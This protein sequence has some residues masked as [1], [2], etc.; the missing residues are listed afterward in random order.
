MRKIILFLTLLVL[1]FSSQNVLENLSLLKK[2]I[3]QLESHLPIH[4]LK[5]L[6]DT[7][8]EKIA[9]PLIENI[10]ITNL[11]N[12]LKGLVFI[13][14]RST[15]K[16][17]KP[18]LDFLKK[19]IRE[20]IASFTPKRQKL[21]KISTIKGD[22]SENIIVTMKGIIKELVIFGA[23]ADDVGSKHAGADDNG[24]GVVS[25]L[26]TMRVI[27]S[28]TFEPIK[29]LQ[30]IFY[31]EEEDEGVGSKHVT[32]LY[33]K[34]N[35][36]V[37]AVLNYDMVGFSKSSNFKTFVIQVHTNKYLNKFLTKIIKQYS[38]IKP[39][40]YDIEYTSDHIR[41]NQTN[42]ASACLK[43]Y[44]WSPHYHKK[45]DKLE[46]INFSYLKEHVKVS[47]AYCIELSS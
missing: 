6:K 37:F 40:K 8:Q 4:D 11:K 3:K 19:T 23:H 34:Q 17:M 29:T 22:K 24:S 18:T 35:K 14:Y 25:V 32:D 13:P 31:T 38:N 2:Q 7:K 12:Y 28:S 15:K 30:F 9:L 36:K 33:K 47:V 46:D 41:W 27:G 42:F 43:E 39:K 21:F 1:V 44:N 5:H 16:G 20:I 26:E 45:T 10:K